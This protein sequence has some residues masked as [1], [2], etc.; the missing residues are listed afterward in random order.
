MQFSTGGVR[1]ATVAAAENCI[2]LRFLWDDFWSAVAKAF[3]ADAQ[4]TIRAAVQTLAWAHFA[5]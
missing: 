3:P 2:V 5:G 1:T 4:E